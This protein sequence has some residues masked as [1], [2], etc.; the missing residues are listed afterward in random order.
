MKED[1]HPE[2]KRKDQRMAHSYLYLNLEKEK[3]F[4][5]SWYL[6]KNRDGRTVC[7]TM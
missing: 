6:N 4:Y 1:E 3:E 7:I 5:S 2:Q